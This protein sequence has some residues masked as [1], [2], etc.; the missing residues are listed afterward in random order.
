MDLSRGHS[1]ARDVSFEEDPRYAASSREA[2]VAVAY[3]LA[4]T[5][6]VV[7]L[8]WGIGGG[9]DAHE[10]SF[11]LGFPAWFFWSCIV[12]TFVFCAVPYVLVK[13]YFIDVPL[14]ADPEEASSGGP[15]VPSGA[16]GGPD[17]DSAAGTR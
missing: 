11:V 17:V 8:A 14:S 3:W 10:M 2:L 1:E 13:R 6:A 5:V 15:D 16:V 7:G 12:A 4:F 9:K